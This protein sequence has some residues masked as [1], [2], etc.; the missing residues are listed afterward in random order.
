[1]PDTVSVNFYV[2]TKD[3]D[4][5][6]AWL[7]ENHM[8]ISTEIVTKD[9]KTVNFMDEMVGD[10]DIPFGR[11]CPA[12][13]IGT[14]EGK[15]DIAAKSFVYDLES[16]K[17]HMVDRLEQGEIAVEMDVAKGEPE[18][19]ALEAFSQY[20]DTKLRILNEWEIDPK[21]LNDYLQDRVWCVD[22]RHASTAPPEPEMDV[23]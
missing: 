16:R 8:S 15:F 23:G 9:E 4:P 7:E 13:F 17:L 14:R 19:S 6:R 10:G 3:A 5:F 20:R 12:S 18:K 22:A 2:A 11:D 21:D 1:M